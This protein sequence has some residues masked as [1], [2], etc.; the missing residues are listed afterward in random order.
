M[1]PI[2]LFLTRLTR[3]PNMGRKG[4][5]FVCPLA[6]D[7]RDHVLKVDVAPDGRVAMHCHYLCPTPAVLAAVGLRL[8][9]L[10]PPRQVGRGRRGPAQSEEVRLRRAGLTDQEIRAVL[11]RARG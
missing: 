1:R 9:D 8:S 7:D 4:W 2:D 6:D 11:A 10:Y 5:K 3:L